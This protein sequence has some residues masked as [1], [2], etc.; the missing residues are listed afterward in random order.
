LILWTIIS[1]LLR[2]LE[3]CGIRGNELNLFK[4]YLSN[5]YQRVKVNNILSD[6]LPVYYSVPQ[7]TILGPLL[8]I[9]Y[10]NGLLNQNIDS[11]E[12]FCFADDTAI[13]FSS[14]CQKNTKS[15]VNTG[16]DKIKTWLNNNSLQI[17]KLQ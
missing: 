17:N 16:L 11:G 5:R 8:F 12:I 6:E 3:Y 7:G 10:L 13:L 14:D 4:S 1:I 2:K 15:I 9:I